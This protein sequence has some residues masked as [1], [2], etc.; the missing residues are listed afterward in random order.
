[1][2]A[3]KQEGREGGRTWQGILR[4]TPEEEEKSTTGSAAGSAAATATA[5]ATG[6]AAAAAAAAAAT[7]RS[8]P[9]LLIARGGIHSSGFFLDS[10]GLGGFDLILPSGWGK[11]FWH[12]MMRRQPH[13]LALP[14]SPLPLG[15]KEREGVEGEWMLPSFPRDFPETREGRRWWREGG[16]EEKEV[17]RR[18][19]KGKRREGGGEVPGFWGG[20]EEEE[21]EEGEEGGMVVIRRAEYL[22]AAV[23]V[24]GAR[25]V[26]NGRV[27]PRLNFYNKYRELRYPLLAAE[28]G[29][30]GREG[31]RVVLMPSPLLLPSYAMG[32]LRCPWGGKPVALAQVYLPS[33]EDYGVW[34]VEKEEEKG[35]GGG[36]RGGKV[37]GAAKNKQRRFAPSSRPASLLPSSSSSSSFERHLLGWTTGG[38]FCL[39]EGQGVALALLN[40]EGLRLLQLRAGGREG[41]REGG[42]GVSAAMAAVVLVRNLRSTIMFPARMGLQVSCQ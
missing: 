9:L 17:E 12:A 15:V 22:E 27:F 42:G 37:E 20:K 13:R 18:R 14:L 21:E 34:E 31:G 33:S 19:P 24:P 16:G 40:I 23:V 41:G 32:V 38:S 26:Y 10:N 28:E 36:G 29:E 35:G 30:E 5:T 7:A 3:E 2:N 1:V 25:D 6:A 39:G 4:G 8:T 11:V